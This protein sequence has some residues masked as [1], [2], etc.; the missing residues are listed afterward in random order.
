MK[1]DRV[2]RRFTPDAQETRVYGEPYETADGSTIVTVV[3]PG[4]GPR[5]A[6][7]LGIFVVHDGKVKWEPVVDTTRLAL[8][9]EFIGLAAAVITTLAILRRPPWPDLSV[10]GLRAMR[11]L[12]DSWQDRR[13]D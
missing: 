1:S 2:I 12:H 8:L 10:A 11:G 3:R 4:G 13:R 5:A 9:G 6:A 7:P